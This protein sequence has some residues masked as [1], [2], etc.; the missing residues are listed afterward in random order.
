MELGS[1][2]EEDMRRFWCRSRLFFQKP[3]GH[4]AF[5]LFLIIF[6]AASQGLAEKQGSSENRV[7]LPKAL[8]ELRST[9]V[10]PALGSVSD[11][12][13][14]E[15]SPGR[16]N[17]QPHLSLNYSSMGAQGLAGMGWNLEIGRVERWRGDG[18]PSVGPADAYSFALAGIGGELRDAGNGVYRAR[19]ENLYREFCLTDSGWEMRDGE[20]SLHRF[21]SRPES[22]LDGRVWMLDEVIDANGN[23]IT[24]FWQKDGGVLYP[25][26]IRYTGVAGSADLGANRIEFKYE[27]RPDTRISYSYFEYEI[28]NKRLKSISAFSSG[29]LVRRYEL[30]YTASSLNDHSLLSQVS[31]VG[32]DNVSTIVLR[33]FQYGTRSLGWNR[34]ITGPPPLDLAD[35]EGR[36]TGAK[37]LDVNGDGFADVV[38]NGANVYL[39]AGNGT[40]YWSST[41]STSLRALGVS[42]VNDD[43][44]DQ[45]VRLIDVNADGKPDI[46]V[47]KTNRRQIHLNNGN[48]WVLSTNWTASLESISQQAIA[49][50]DSSF[51]QQT[52][53]CSPPHCDGP[54]GAFP[55][56]S[57]PHCTGTNDPA[58]CIPPHCQPGQTTNCTP[59]HC[60]PLLAFNKPAVEAFSLVEDDGDSKGVQLV[61]V[62]GDGR[63][64]ILWSMSRQESLYWLQFRMPVY[65]RGVFLNTGT[66]W[67]RND[68]LT[69]ALVAFDGEFVTDSVIQGYDVLD[70]NG[71]GLGDIVRTQAGKTR[72]VFLGTGQNWV[73]D[74]TY[75]AAL[76]NTEIYS[77]D[78]DRRGQGLMPADFNDDGLVDYFRAN[79]SVYKAYKNT[80]VG[81][82]EVP[83]LSWFLQAY[84]ISFNTS[85]GKSSG[86]VLT[87]VDGDGLSDV[88]YAKNGSRWMLLSGGMR[89]GLLVHAT[90]P[91]GEVTDISWMMSTALTNHDAAGL[92]QLPSPM[93]VAQSLVHR[94]GSKAWTT[95]YNYSGGLFEERQFR[96]FAYSRET[97]PTGFYFLRQ[98]HQEEGLA[99]QNVTEQG[100][101]GQ[102]NVRIRRSA[103]FQTVA[104]TP[105]IKQFQRV[106]SD[107]EAIDP[108]G[109]T[110]TRVL[111]TYDDHLNTISVWRDPDVSTPGGETTT[112]F[113][114]A[115][116]NQNGIWSLPSHIVAK[117][118]D[119]AVLSESIMLYDGLPEGQAL[120]GLPTTMRELVKAGTYVSRTLEYDSFGNI[121]RATD[122]AGGTSQFGYDTT[123]TFRIWAVDPEG[124][125]VSSTYDP[126]FGEV[127][128]DTDAGGNVTS[129]EYDAFGRLAR[130]RLP[131]DQSSPFGTR[132]YEFSPLGNPGTQFYR[133]RET[134]TPGTPDTL[135]TTSFFD[136]MGLIY[137]VE[138]E[139]SGGRKVIGLTEFDD[140]GNPV[141]VSRPFYE[142]ETPR[143][144]RIERDQL[145]R[146]AR[147]VEPDD[148]ELR[149]AYT[150]PKVEVKDRREITTSFY[151]N[152]EGQVTAIR[153]KNAGA[154]QMTGYGYDPLGRLISITD[155][156]GAVTR[157]TYD[158]R[159]QRVQL[160]DP[161]AGTYRY[162]YDGEGRIR[163]Q[164]APGGLVTLYLY[165]RAGDLTGKIFPDGTTQSFAYGTGTGNAVGRI[166]H[167]EDAAGTLDLRYDVRGNVVE[168]RRTVLGQTYVTGYSYDSM[169]R[170]RRITYPD[171]F[172]V[173]YE[174]D[175]GGNLARV[176]DGQGRLVAE[177]TAYTAAGQLKEMAFGNGVRSQ[178]GYDEL[179]RMTSIRTMGV[180]NSPL[181]SLDYSYDPDGNILSIDDRILQASQT[182]Q[183]D[184]LGRLIRAQGPYG[185]ERYQ[186]DAVGNLI[187]KGD[188]IMG[189]DPAHP[190]QVICAMDASLGRGNANGIVNNP[191]FQ[192][193]MDTLQALSH[194]QDAPMPGNGGNPNLAAFQL[195]YDARGNVVTKGDLRFAYDAENHMVQA[196]DRT[197]KLIEKNIYDSGGRRVVQWTPSDTTI[198][199]DGIYEENQT[200][201]SR[202]VTAGN[203]VVAT[204]VT[205]RATVR[206]IQAAPEPMLASVATGWKRWSGFLAGGPWWYVLP[207]LLTG[208]V[209][210]VAGLECM[211]RN[212]RWRSELM[213]AGLALRQRPARSFVTI[214]MVPVMT[215][216]ATDWATAEVR[217]STPQGKGNAQ[218][219]TR[220]YY[221][222]NH[223]GSVS[224]M[225]DDRGSV[226]ARRDYKPYGEAVELSGAQGGPRELLMTYNGQRYEESTGLYQLGVRHYDP[227]TGRFM[228]ADT[229]V[230]D[231]MNPKTLNRYAYAGGNPIR[232][233]DPSGHAWYDFLIAAFVILVAIVITVATFGALAG[234]GVAL[235]T[236]GA[237]LIAAA[238][239]LSQGLNPL[240]EQFWRTVVTGM[241]LGAV[242]GAG[243]FALPTMLAG[244]ATFLETVASMALVGAATG[245]IESSI[246]HFASGGGADSLLG[247]LLVGIG[248]GFV[249]GAVAGG[250]MGGLTQLGTLG[251]MALKAVNVIK[252]VVR[253]GALAFKA[254][255]LTYAALISGL[256]RREQ[257]LTGDLLSLIPGMGDFNGYF[258]SPRKEIG[259]PS[260]ALSGTWPGLI[261]SQPAG[262]TAALLQTMPLAR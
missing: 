214:L 140:A 63:L 167:I 202:H 218:S 239:A 210:L 217:A 184:D 148:I 5:I 2:K 178:F 77:L 95:T 110:H 121:V 92:E 55:G 240:S 247:D 49:L 30:S 14:I 81:W 252:T 44:A 47:A 165:N 32:A 166:T 128:S 158:A 10:S 145:H 23:S 192:A 69:D 222:A 196:F 205:P 101:D 108:G 242:I 262:G 71:D 260:W 187:R 230:P 195:T 144:S 26:E 208:A 241:V 94:N 89:A 88:V 228:T 244:G 62:N 46:F 52:S 191:R 97:L 238:I 177:E 223:L 180:T 169:G 254:V 201:A 243:L 119:G 8:G 114:W 157:L 183:Y 162:E 4:I 28:N 105:V 93:P 91:L 136:G 24:F 103:I 130:L 9:L 221:H 197:G 261:G 29:Q 116:N 220:Y 215:M 74:A 50:G 186:Y 231:P 61:D 181:Q 16:R 25:S 104:V 175:S 45:G 173:N 245:A 237:G 115:R 15:V 133:M 209:F 170:I 87:D 60:Q 194:R 164:T 13:P 102:N 137:R 250:F 86:V 1:V 154:E 90:N 72:E 160:D 224:V 188:L 246:S 199:I 17:V 193:C 172:T 255:S 99:G 120:R 259:I 113:S 124:R 138:R 117:G 84:G 182:F 229:Q 109:A 75:S 96:G 219:E 126:R 125:R 200:H 251:S 111:N 156:Q 206:L 143:M 258:S 98:H 153:Q 3:A 40:F 56:C 141:Q 11:R 233:V 211:R 31:L 70:V 7:P 190:H 159:G 83:I 79:G 67:V 42:F 189:V 149:L 142:G 20:G 185:D 58:G 146:P 37:V 100:V 155:A 73:K 204:V 76:S 85:D 150:G 54:L 64:D 134:E 35:S 112:T 216:V 163:T 122:R 203:Q 253:A 129:K 225:T 213:V 6:L 152:T 38:D 57:P 234:V 118:P 65:V 235:F 179:L 12:I 48:G 36:E 174:Y 161:N 257:S 198:F 68:V 227:Q 127:T 249:T 248:M 135:D 131:G 39:G 78:S 171:G 147:V 18:T 53:S 236:V 256:T 207:L 34:L 22:R 43:G 132:S 139:G 59:A 21:G 232:Y 226:T 123:G 107:E 80:G 33:T 66:G 41:W 82:A 19:L 106:Q 51:F 27:T 168:R 212:K 176:R 151:R